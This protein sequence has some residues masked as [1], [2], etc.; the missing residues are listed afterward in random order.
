MMVKFEPLAAGL[1]F[2]VEPCIM[3]CLFV[4]ETRTIQDCLPIFL[5]LADL[6]NPCFDS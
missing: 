4:F 6:M 5:E 2:E 1:F 3:C